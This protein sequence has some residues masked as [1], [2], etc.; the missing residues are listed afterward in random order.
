MATTHILSTLFFGMLKPV[1]R[2]LRALSLSVAS[3]CTPCQAGR[4]PVGI[5]WSGCAAHL[6]EQLSSHA[7]K[8]DADAKWQPSPVLKSC[9]A[10]VSHLLADDVD[11]GQASILQQLADVE[12]R[13]V[14]GA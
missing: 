1:C 11:G 8:V 5:Q 7:V 3:T 12:L 6:C 4:N 14:Q 13:E 2:T 9:E 10:L